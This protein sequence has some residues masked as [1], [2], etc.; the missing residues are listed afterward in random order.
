[1]VPLPKSSRPS[2]LSHLN[3]ARLGQM[4]SLWFLLTFRLCHF[5]PCS[6]L[7]KTAVW[8]LFLFEKIALKRNL[9]FGIVVL[10][11]GRGSIFSSYKLLVPNFS[12]G[13]SFELYSKNSETR[14]RKKGYLFID[15]DPHFLF[16]KGTKG[17]FWASPA[18]SFL[19]VWKNEFNFEHTFQ[20]RN[21]LDWHEETRVWIILQFWI[22]FEKIRQNRNHLHCS[23]NL[24][25]K[26]PCHLNSPDIS[27]SNWKDNFCFYCWEWARVNNLTSKSL[28]LKVICHVQITALI[29]NWGRW[30]N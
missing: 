9:P 4:K 21:C 22:F 8:T 1:M 23:K 10:F 15:F 13:R 18:Y 12:F 7:W 6:F 28:F 5:P 25:R 14:I 3:P 29:L 16:E 26:N 17:A 30:K 11:C 19:F 24:S 20:R 2:T 27:V